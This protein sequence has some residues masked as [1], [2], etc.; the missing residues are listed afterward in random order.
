MLTIYGNPMSTCT[1]KVLMTLAET[2]TPYELQVLDFAKAD[3]KSEAHLRRQPFGRIPAMGDDGFEMFESRAICRYVA[4]KANSPLLPSELRAF[5]KVEQWISIETSEFS[6]SA[7]KF[8]YHHVFQRPQEAATMEA[9][10]KAL[11]TTCAI[12]DRQLAQTPFIAGAELSLADI[13]FMPYLEYA[14]NTPA[15]EVVAKHRHVGAWWSKL[16]ERP[17]WKKI[18]GRGE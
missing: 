16:A 18:V 7:M 2:N 13:M 4:R 14:M 17:T 5:A 10:A 3:H 6:A 8:V 9:A 15:K 1:R 12:M 11:E